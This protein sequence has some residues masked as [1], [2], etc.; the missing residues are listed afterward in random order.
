MRR[1]LP[2][3]R[4]K[5]KIVAMSDPDTSKD[6]RIRI[7]IVGPDRAEDVLAA[8]RAAFAEYQGVL[9]PPS[10]ATTESLD[11]VRAGITEG[12]ALLAWLDGQVVGT[13]RWRSRGDHLYAERV[14]VLPGARGHGIGVTLMRAIESAARAA[15]LAEVRLAT[16]AALWRNL[17]FYE[18]LGYRTCASRRHP[19]GPDYEITLSKDVRGDER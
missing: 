8:T 10:G 17:R 16:R 11:D 14:G 3:S 1:I 2:A 19:R 12:G 4:E 6:A 5:G 7:E 18:G 15:G 9:D 13:G